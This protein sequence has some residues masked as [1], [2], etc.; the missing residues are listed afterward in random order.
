MRLRTL[1]RIAAIAMAVA[2]GSTALSAQSGRVDDAKSTRAD[3]VDARPAFAVL[4][5]VTAAPMAPRELG[6]VKGQFA[7]FWNPG[8]PFP[9]AAPHVVNGNNMSNWSDLYGQGPVGPGYHGLCK[10]VTRSPAIFIN[11]GG[12]C[13]F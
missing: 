2:L 4:K 5:G 7:H 12:G 3:S 11:P 9:E 6:T 13:G 8:A 1:L 10:A